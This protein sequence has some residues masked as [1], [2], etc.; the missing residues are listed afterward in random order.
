MRTRKKKKLHNGQKKSKTAIKSKRFID[1]AMG[2]CAVGRPQGD[3]DGIIGIYRCSEKWQAERNSKFH[4]RGEWYEVDCEVNGEMFRRMVQTKLISDIKRKLLGYDCVYVQMDGARAHV[5]FWEDLVELGARRRQIDGQ[6]TPIIRF[7]KQPAN[8][9][10]TNLLDLCFFRSLAK[11]V[12]KKERKFKQGY[13]GKESFWKHVVQTFHDYHAERTMDRC[14]RTKSAVVQSILDA[15]GT[16]DYELPHGYR[17]E[18]NCSRTQRR[19]ERRRRV[20][21]AH[22]ELRRCP[23]SHSLF[24]A[25][26]SASIKKFKKSQYRVFFV[27]FNTVMIHKSI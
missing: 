23:W 17:V 18:T 4:A 8:S 6:K 10:D 21:G 24:S 12:S 11:L 14:W 19:F 27:L 2:L 22:A 5:K 7:V 16:N 13:E 25:P 15:Q 9:P 1:K 20:V 3:F 26:L